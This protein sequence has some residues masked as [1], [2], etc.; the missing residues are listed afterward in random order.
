MS[1][2]K[3]SATKQ[4]IDE[5]IK[6]LKDVKIREDID[7]IDVFF[8][9]LC[10]IYG[11]KI[12]WAIYEGNDIEKMLTER[13]LS[14]QDFNEIESMIKNGKNYSDQNN[15]DLNKLYEVENSYNDRLLKYAEKVRS[16]LKEDNK[17]IDLKIIEEAIKDSFEV[18]ASI[19]TPCSEYEKNNEKKM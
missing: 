16:K 1:E 19:Y 18:N 8:P 3:N 4:I 7:F 6:R 13:G 15:D 17:E 5:T 12:C 9:K 14:K 2:V 11:T 10:A